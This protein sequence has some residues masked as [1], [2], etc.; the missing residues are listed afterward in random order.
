MKIFGKKL[1]GFQ[2]VFQRVI[3]LN[4]DKK[5]VFSWKENMTD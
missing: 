2:K 5:S 1:I 4:S 3:F